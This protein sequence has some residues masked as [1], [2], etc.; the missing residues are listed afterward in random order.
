MG[1]NI[2]I[3][4]QPKNPFYEQRQEKIKQNWERQ[5]KHGKKMT[6]MKVTSVKMRYQI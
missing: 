3:N 4:S 2:L 5:K 1:R 6:P